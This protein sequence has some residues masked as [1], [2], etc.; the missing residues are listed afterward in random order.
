M[1][2][3]VITGLVTFQATGTV[4]R[5]S[6]LGR[7][8]AVRVVTAHAMEGAFTLLKTTALTQA[9]GVVVDLKSLRAALALLGHVHLN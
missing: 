1:H 9:V 3:F 8:L 4:V 6:I 5:G 7:R 2:R